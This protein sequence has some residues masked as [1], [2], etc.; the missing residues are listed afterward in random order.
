MRHTE[1]VE[2]FHQ[3]VCESFGSQFSFFRKRCCFFG[4]SLLLCLN[5]ARE[6]FN[7]VAGCFH[8]VQFLFP[9]ASQGE[10]IGVGRNMVFLFKLIDRIESLLHEVES[11][12]IELH[13]VGVEQQTV[14]D[15]I[16]FDARLFKSFCFLLHSR[17]VGCDSV[18]SLSGSAKEVEHVSFIGLDAS[19]GFKEGLFDFF[20]VGEHFLLLLQTFLFALFPCQLFEFLQIE[21]EQIFLA[22]C[23]LSLLSELAKTSGGVLPLLI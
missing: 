10:Q 15:V 21:G 6:F 20:C 11:S 1:R 22:L 12:G 8:L 7:F 2:Q 17:Q 4:E 14:L 18:H 16:D 13:F 23:F 9:F 5:L 19:G 3:F